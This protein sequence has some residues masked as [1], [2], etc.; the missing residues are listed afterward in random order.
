MPLDGFTL[1]LCLKELKES[2][3][4]SRIEKIHMPTRDSLLLCLRSKQ[5]AKKLLISAS[6]DSARIHLTSYDAENPKQP[7]MLCMFFRKHLTGGIITAIE[8]NGLDRQVKLSILASNEL[9]DKVNFSLYAEIMAKRSNIILVN[10]EGIILEAIKRVDESK[11]SFR[12]LLPGFKYVPAPEQGKMNILKSDNDKIIKRILS[13]PD[14]ALSQAIL[15]SIEGA[16]PLI[17]REIAALTCRG[18]IQAGLLNE[19]EL[20]RLCTALDKLRLILQGKGEPVIL[21]EGERLIDFTFMPITQYGLGV[22]QRSVG[23]LCE[24]FENFYFEKDRRDRTRQVSSSLIKTVSTLLQRARRKLEM[25]IEDRKNCEGKDDLKMYAE[26]INANQYSLKKGSFYYDLP[27]YYDSYKI[28]RIKANPALTPNANAQKYYK[29]YT[30]LKNAQRHLSSL[31]EQSRTEVEYLESIEDAVNRADSY[32]AIEEIKAELAEQGY[33]KRS[34]VK[35]KKQK[36]GQPLRY[37]SDD[38]YEILVGRNNFQNELISFKI[39]AKDDSWFHIQKMPG[40]HVVVIGNGDII[41]ERTCR[42]AAILAA[43]HSSGDGLTRVPVDY[44]VIKQLHHPKNGKPGMV[45]Y[46]TYNTMWVEPDRETVK[47]LR[48]GC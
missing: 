34:T 47:R 5:G 27:N 2:I 22:T 23:S 24:C 6:A 31:I 7:P 37:I 28:I 12:Q 26:L 18:D 33:L 44:T 30:K 13:F 15:G 43:Y 4:F 32:S 35:N 46:Q 36:P 41:P 38:G 14:K 40:S 9:G 39:A 16:S 42:Q 29:E 19:S 10:E 1:S 21:S 48:K 11:N 25:R 45:I 8:Q 17:A 20:E 3:L